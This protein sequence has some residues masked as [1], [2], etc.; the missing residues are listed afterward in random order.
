[1]KWTR[2]HDCLFVRELLLSEPWKYKK[3]TPER[4][5]IW[6]NIAASLEQVQDPKF[7]TDKH[8]V[9]DR[10]NKLIKDHKKKVKDEQRTS[11]LSLERD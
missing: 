3:G 6:A 2:K 1:M 8:S 9:R 4:K 10:F 7:K 11:G 5:E